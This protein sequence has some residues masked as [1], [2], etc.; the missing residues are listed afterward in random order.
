[1]PQPALKSITPEEY[2]AMED[3]ADSK[4]EYYQGKIFDMA[5]ASQNHTR[6]TLDLGAS[7]TFA[8]KN[9][10]CEAYPNDMKVWSKVKNYFTYPDL[11]IV[12]G[13]AEFYEDRDDILTN[14]LVIFEVLS[15]STRN[16]D[17]DEKFEFY[18]SIPSFQEYI[19]IDQ[20]RVH[21][22]QMYLETRNKWILSEYSQITDVLKLAKV[23]IEIPLREIYRRVEFGESQDQ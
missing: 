14:P 18:R 7:A 1:M 5:G 21:V 11:I 4:H 17:R 23:D 19:L 2:L 13:K 12:C 20:W 15:K 6:I 22:E 9:S 8:L 10:N 16:Y 3:A